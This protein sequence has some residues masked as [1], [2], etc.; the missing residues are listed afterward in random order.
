[1][2]NR[3]IEESE[4]FFF[5]HS[6]P[7]LK[8]RTQRKNLI[9]PFSHYK[10][11]PNEISRQNNNKNPFNSFGTLTKN[12]KKRKPKNFSPPIL[13]HQQRTN[14]RKSQLNPQQFEPKINSFKSYH[15][16]HFW[17]NIAPTIENNK[18]KPT[19]T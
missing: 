17:P 9:H 15:N 18:N 11:Q 4:L 3:N 2:L 14:L 10:E 19:T 5:A 13:G 7:Q 1:L 6:I 12:K 8:N 16:I